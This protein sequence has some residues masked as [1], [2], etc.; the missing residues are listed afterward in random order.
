MG[1]LNYNI[2]SSNANLL[3]PNAG[4]YEFDV[5]VSCDGGV[6][7]KGTL[8]FTSVDKDSVFAE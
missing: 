5:T 4:L 2:I 3:V 8:L 1:F 7:A 6:R